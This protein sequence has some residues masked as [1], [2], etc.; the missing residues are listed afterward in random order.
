MN[1]KLTV[2]ENLRWEASRMMLPEHREA[3]LQQ[4][5]KGKVKKRPEVC[6]EEQEQIGI[7]LYESMWTGKEVTLTL[8]Q[9][10]GDD[11]VLEGVV[12]KINATTRLIHMKCIEEIEC[13]HFQEIIQIH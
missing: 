2:G 1:N 13:I 7:A 12:M 8:F 6:E 5:R 4:Q 10:L 3:L 11:T 9:E